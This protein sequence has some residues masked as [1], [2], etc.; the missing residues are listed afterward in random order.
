MGEWQCDCCW[1]RLRWWCGAADGLS[2][3]ADEVVV[4]EMHELC[5]VASD[6]SRPIGRSATATAATGLLAVVRFRLGTVSC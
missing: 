2:L 1:S 3:A 6:E 5:A 4:M